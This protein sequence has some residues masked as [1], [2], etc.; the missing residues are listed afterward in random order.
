MA[1]HMQNPGGQAGASRN[2]LGGWLLPSLTAADR[3]SQLLASRFL[4]SPPLA[5]DVARLCFGDAA[6]D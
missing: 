1:A 6:N 5:R 3:Q 4:L 2:Q